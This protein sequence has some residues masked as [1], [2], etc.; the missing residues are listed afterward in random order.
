MHAAA[1]VLLFAVSRISNRVNARRRPRVG[2]NQ[3]S[4]DSVVFIL[5]ATLADLPSSP[6]PQNNC[7]FVGWGRKNA[8]IRPPIQR[9][10]GKKLGRRHPRAR[11]LRLC[12]VERINRARPQL[13]RGV[14][15]RD[16]S[17]RTPPASAPP[18]TP[19][20][21]LRSAPADSAA[22]EAPMASP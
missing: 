7:R 3:P 6:N 17:V 12:G 10:L 1:R 22:A 11:D 13:V 18:P 8:P 5:R 14:G 9:R 15:G 19:I 20:S 21:S 4:R 16:I 2:R